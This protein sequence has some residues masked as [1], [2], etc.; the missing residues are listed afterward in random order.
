MK[1]YTYFRSS[2]SYR[3]RIALHLKDLAFDSVPI[4]LV[5]GEQGMAEYLAKNPKGSSLLFT[6]TVASSHSRLR[7]WII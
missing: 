5:K 3:V 4:H 1:L 7:F 2:A 6:W